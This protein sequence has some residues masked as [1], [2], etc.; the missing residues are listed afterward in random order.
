MCLHHAG[1]FNKH[2]YKHAG[3]KVSKHGWAMIAEQLYQWERLHGLG[4]AQ[5]IAVGGEDWSHLPGQN[6]IM[7]LRDCWVRDYDK[8]DAERTGDHFDLYFVGQGLVSAILW[9]EDFPSGPF[10]LIG[11]CRDGKVRYWPVS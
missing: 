8:S 4:R 10:G 7:Y 3:N 5:E 1:A 6:G 2:A 9:P 11:S